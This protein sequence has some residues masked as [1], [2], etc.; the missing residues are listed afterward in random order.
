MPAN[1]CK[2][3]CQFIYIDKYINDKIVNIGVSPNQEL[4]VIQWRRQS[5][6]HGLL[7]QVRRY[8]QSIQDGAYHFARPF[9]ASSLHAGGF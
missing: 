3:K 4:P 2:K 9:L 1:L 5:G 7:D 6:L 8:A